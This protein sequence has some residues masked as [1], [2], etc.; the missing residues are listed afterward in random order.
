M[1]SKEKLSPVAPFTDKALTRVVETL[2]KVGLRTE[3]G[4]LHQVQRQSSYPRGEGDSLE[5]T[6]RLHGTRFYFYMG[7]AGRVSRIEATNLYNMGAVPLERLDQVNERL[8]EIL[9]E[10]N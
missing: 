4:F 5:W 6:E 8:A 2:T 3:H 9:R 7:P 1:S 10:H